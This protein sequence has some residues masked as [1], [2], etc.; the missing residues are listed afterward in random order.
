MLDIP[1]T[2][3]GAFFT[4]NPFPEAVVVLLFAIDF[5]IN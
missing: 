2:E 4:I 5:L 3:V 1:G